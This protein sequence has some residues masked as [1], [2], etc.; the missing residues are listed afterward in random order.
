MRS[1]RSAAYV[2]VGLSDDD[3]M[4]KDSVIECINEAGSVKA[5]SSMT[6][7]AGGK[8]DAPRSGIVSETLN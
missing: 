4:G 7:A 1:T 3:K 8:Y 5:F 2:A 6:I